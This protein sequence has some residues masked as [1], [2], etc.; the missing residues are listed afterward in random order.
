MQNQNTIDYTTVLISKLYYGRQTHKL[1]PPQL[2]KHPPTGT[3]YPVRICRTELDYVVLAPG[4]LQSIAIR[5]KSVLIP[6]HDCQGSDPAFHKILPVILPVSPGP[7]GSK[8][9]EILFT[10]AGRR[11]GCAL[12]PPPLTWPPELV[13]MSSRALSSPALNLAS[14]RSSRR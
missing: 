11:K 14:S 3:C 7:T 9:A 5:G 13:E 12:P 4:E 10:K 8:K 6:H 2:W 1:L